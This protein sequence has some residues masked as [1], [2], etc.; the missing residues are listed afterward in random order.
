VSIGMVAAA[1]IAAALGRADADLA[2]RI[3]G[4][5]DAWGLPVRCPPHE[6]DAIW[7]AMTHDKK[8]RG[9]ALRWIL[10]QAIGQ[11]EI[12]EDVAPSVVKSVLQDLGARRSE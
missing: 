2:V 9:R 5:L 11:V 6:V 12:V 3:E 8:R 1:H 4:A 10:P 7:E